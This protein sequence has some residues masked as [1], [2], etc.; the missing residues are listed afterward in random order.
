M[1]LLENLA[2]LS[3]FD[4]KL[5][6]KSLNLIGNSDDIWCLR[7]QSEWTGQ[8]ATLR[9]DVILIIISFANNRRFLNAIMGVFSMVVIPFNFCNI[10]TLLKT[11]VLGVHLVKTT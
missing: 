2:F 7:Q 8:Q 11:R 6:F 10:L 5:R 4:F 3:L 1:A 9:D